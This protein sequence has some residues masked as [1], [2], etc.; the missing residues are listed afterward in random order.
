[1]TI[2]IIGCWSLVI[3]NPKYITISRD[4]EKNKFFKEILILGFQRSIQLGSGLWI[5][6][7][8][9]HLPILNHKLKLFNFTE[10]LGQKERSS[11]DFHLD[12]KNDESSIAYEFMQI[13]IIVKDLKPCLWKIWNLAYD[14]YRK[15]LGDEIK[16]SIK[17][18]RI[19]MN[20]NTVVMPI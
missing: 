2:M 3:H 11:N 19:F 4:L 20:N 13:C 17:K 16:I 8:E 14:A 10:Y 1:M 18:D 15:R 9:S 5:K 7:T 6:E 12:E